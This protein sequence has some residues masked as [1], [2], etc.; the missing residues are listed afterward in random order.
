MFLSCHNIPPFICRLPPFLKP[1]KYP[2]HFSNISTPL[3]YIPY[4]FQKKIK[5][6]MVL[7]ESN[8]PL[9][10]DYDKVLQYHCSTKR[11]MVLQRDDHK[12]EIAETLPVI[13]LLGLMSIDER[14]RAK[15]A[16][17]ISRASS[18]WGFFQVV[19]H[20]VSPKLLSQ[21]RREQINLF[22][23]SFAI[24]SSCGLLNNSYRW[25]TPTATSPDNFSWSEA[26]HIP[27]TKISNENC[28]GEFPSL[29][30]TFMLND[31]LI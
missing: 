22:N 17:E 8:P 15:C 27:L 2:F 21:M 31:H 28:Y 3:I 14:E 18:E 4:H 24:K 30:Y 7:I 23:A 20:G 9:A 10:Q 5:N 29:R 1:Y 25:G 11:T 12:R 6:K 26:F 16:A 19:N 13:D